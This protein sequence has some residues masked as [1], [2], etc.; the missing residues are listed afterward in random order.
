MNSAWEEYILI[1]PLGRVR[2]RSATNEDG[3]QVR[4]VVYGVLAEYGLA[5]DPHG[6]DSDLW[7]L[8]KSYQAPGGLFYVLEEENQEIAGCV[9]LMLKGDSV[10]E[11]RKM[12]LL[13]RMRGQGI[14]RFLLETMLRRARALSIRRIELETSSC[15]EDALRM[16]R[17]YGFQ[18]FQADHMAQRADLALALDLG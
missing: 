8:E 1:A 10:A 16:Y 2:L 11:L 9:G 6:T 5:A 15:L 3:P 12:Y 14:G 7:D 18:P 4:E 17:W 13:P